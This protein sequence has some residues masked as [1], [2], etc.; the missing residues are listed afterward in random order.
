V[1]DPINKNLGAMRAVAARLDAKA[2]EA[3]KI[4][5]AFE[6]L[7]DE[8]D[9]EVTAEVCFESRAATTAGDEDDTSRT[10]FNVSLG[11]GRVDGGYRIHVVEEPRRADLGPGR[12]RD[13]GWQTVASARTTWPSCPRGLRLRSFAALPTLLDTITAEAGQLIGAAAA[14]CEALRGVVGPTAAAAGEGTP[15]RP[16]GDPAAGRAAPPPRRTL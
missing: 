1:T 6:A 4:V 14:A 8:L 15:S 9:L 7:L 10:E 11:Y 13:S 12:C 5:Q 16:Q 2:A 3:A